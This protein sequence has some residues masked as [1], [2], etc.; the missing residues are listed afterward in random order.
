MINELRRT[1]R[2]LLQDGTV[3]VVIGYGQVAA[4]DRVFPVFIT[5]PEDVDQL[6]WNEH[7]FANLTKYLTRKE[8][9]ALGKAAICVK[10]CD[11]R[12][13]VVLEKESQ[14]DR[15]QLVVIGLA[16]D[17]VG[18]PRLPKC[19]SCDVHTPR[20]ADVVIGQS[21]SNANV[22]LLGTS[23]ASIEKSTGNINTTGR[24]A[25][26]EEFMKNTP[27][28]RLAY[29]TSELSRCI[30]CYACRQACPMCYC[31][32]CIVDKN[33]PVV[34]CSSATL[35]GNI[36]WQITRAFHLA[37]RC[38]G[39]DECTRVCPVGIDLRLLNLSL[40]KAAE[41]NFSFRAGIDPNTDPIIGAYREQD[42]E[43][44]IL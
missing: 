41:E 7:C 22:P 14:I 25:A 6:V 31:R 5:K 18:D 38:V 32:Q 12:A 8:T 4:G 33:R 42:H 35:K 39:C 30:K 1:C 2:Q 27:E 36:A 10:G 9:Q 17:G 24:Y 11:E 21:L 37:G 16:C 13:I 43:E 28:E 34:V 26:L 29:W 15:S 19:E 23:S 44:F 20:R 3:R 40:A